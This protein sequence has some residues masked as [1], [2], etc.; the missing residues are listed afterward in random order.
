MYEREKN[1]E[2]F[3]VADVGFDINQTIEMLNELGLLD[4]LPDVL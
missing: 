1:K 4:Q 3:D 2:E